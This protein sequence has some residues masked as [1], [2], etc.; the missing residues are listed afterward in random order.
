MAPACL[1]DIE[2]AREVRLH[3]GTGIVQRMAHTGLRGEMQNVLGFEL[4]EQ[5]IET[6]AIDNVHARKAEPTHVGERREP[7]LFEPDVVIVVK[8]VYAGNFMTI[9]YESRHAV[10]TDKSSAAC[11][12]DAE[13]HSVE[14]RNLMR[15]LSL[16]LARL[17]RSARSSWFIIALS[18]D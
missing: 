10:K 18:S 16:I 6:G 1:E 14:H 7:C 2:E 3:V 15:R 17:A 8:I 9:A 13:R 11:D 5:L 12:E 4:G